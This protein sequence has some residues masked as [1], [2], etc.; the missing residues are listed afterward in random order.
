M[1]TRTVKR[2]AIIGPQ[3]NRLAVVFERANFPWRSVVKHLRTG[4]RLVKVEITWKEVALAV[5]GKATWS[6]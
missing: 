5:G 3:A 6:K 4:Q 1:K 2:F